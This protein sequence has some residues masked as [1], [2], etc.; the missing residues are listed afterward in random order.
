MEGV[1]PKD[2]AALRKVALKL[3][4]Q[5]LPPTDSKKKPAGAHEDK[6]PSTKGKLVAVNVPLDFELK[7]LDPEHPYLL[8]RNFSRKTIEFFGLGF[9]SRGYFKDRA[10][11]PLHDNLGRAVG[12]AGRVVDNDAINE[13]NPRYL[14]PGSRER[15]GNVFEFRKS[16]FLYNG[17]RITA[18]VDQLIIVEGFPSVWWLHQNG[19]TNVVAT[20]GGSLSDEQ[21][22]IV[23]EKVSESGIVWIFSDGNKAGERFETS[24]FT[25]IAP[26]RAVRLLRSSEGKQPTD[27]IPEELQKRLTPRARSEGR[28]SIKVRLERKEITTRQAIIELAQSLPALQFLN[29]TVE[30]WEP[31]KI[32]A[33]AERLSTGE[34]ACVQF[35]LHV[36]DF[37]RSWKA[38]SP[39][40]GTLDTLD[41]TH[42]KVFSEWA[43]DPWWC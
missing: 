7:D 35:L 19:T 41:K 13:D 34:R 21:A 5:F 15:D 14:F 1:S 27:Y 9:C 2:G 11:I 33:L 10:A 17:F 18:P 16:L 20:M 28:P 32:D 26:I 6:K 4:E 3:Q 37:H 36:W 8:S 12:Y 42:R 22:A 38:G 24:I 39:N 43:A 30:K 31:E 23:V 40:M 29:L 25:R